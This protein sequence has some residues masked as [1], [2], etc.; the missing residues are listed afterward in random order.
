MTVLSPRASLVLLATLAVTACGGGATAPS[1]AATATPDPARLLV[2]DP[3]NF[4]ALVLT[5]A[6]TSLVEFQLP[7]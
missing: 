6:G 7:T 2:L 5:P 1:P 3:G 4:D